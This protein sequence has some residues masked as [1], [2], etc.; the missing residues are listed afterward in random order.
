MTDLT[1]IRRWCDQARPLFIG[2]LARSGTSMLCA[3]L[4]RHPALFPLKR[5]GETFIF[6]KPRAGLATESTPPGLREYLGSADA[7]ALLRRR[8]ADADAAHGQALGDVDVARLF[9]H[10]VAHEVYPG[11]RPLEKTPGH[12][13]KLD[14]VFQ[15]FPQAL[16]LVCVRDPVQIV[17]SYR[18]RLQESRQMGLP[19]ARLAW[20]DRSIEDMTGIFTRFG[21]AWEHARR[22][23]GQ[24]VLTV[25]YH[26]VTRSPRIA[27][28]RICQAAGLAACE[29]LAE[30]LPDE[31]LGF[32]GGVIAPRGGDHAEWVSP[33]E[34][35]QVRKAC[36][37]WLEAWC[38]DTLPY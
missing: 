2:G 35:D 17:A 16:A 4:A 22:H 13:L 11:R 12:A 23:H 29:H 33:S 20:L 6:I 34:A 36:S 21:R 19:P 8:L 1:Q 15:A 27:L 37:P 25:P 26:A 7:V 24:H 10:A 9:F 31:E 30:P 38:A 3:V 32:R 5:P 14:T 28:Q 18:K